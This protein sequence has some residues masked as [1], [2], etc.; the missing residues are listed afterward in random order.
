M[1]NELFGSR[2]AIVKAEILQSDDSATAQK[3]GGRDSES[4]ESI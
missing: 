4:L 1:D 2:T 3:D